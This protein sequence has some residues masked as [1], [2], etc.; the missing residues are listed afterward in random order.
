MRPR[1]TGVPLVREL[2]D[3]EEPHPDRRLDD[4][5]LEPGLAALEVVV[6][7]DDEGD[8][9]PLAIRPLEGPVPMPA[10]PLPGVVAIEPEAL[11]DADRAVP[12]ERRGNIP[13]RAFPER[14]REARVVQ[15]DPRVIAHPLRDR[16]TEERL[17][18][19]FTEAER[20]AQ[21]NIRRAL[22]GFEEPRQREDVV[23]YPVEFHHFE[24]PPPESRVPH[25]R[26]PERSA[27]P[28]DAGP[29]RPVHR[30]PS[31]RGAARDHSD[32]IV[33]P[34]AAPHNP[35]NRYNPHFHPN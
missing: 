9:A 5:V 29:R 33:T 26:I 2:M 27:R 11:V 28:S 23:G 20:L 35:Q 14:L 22:V 6:Q 13:F 34:T 31:R 30:R 15:D 19:R 18:R 25:R 17:D 7:V 24:R 16:R 32:S 8:P 1:V 12:A 10:E 3:E 4:D 21:V